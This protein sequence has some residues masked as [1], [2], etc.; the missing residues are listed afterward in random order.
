MRLSPETL[1]RHSERVRQN[2]Q[3]ELPLQL[4]KLTRRADLCRYCHSC[5]MNVADF[6]ACREA[7]T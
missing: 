1:A 3:T 4:P 2:D 5:H 6:I 7:N